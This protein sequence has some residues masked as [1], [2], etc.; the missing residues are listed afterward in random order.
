MK[1][2]DTLLKTISNTSDEAYDRLFNPKHVH[3]RPLHSRPFPLHTRVWYLV[4]SVSYLSAVFGLLEHVNRIEMAVDR[5]MSSMTAH[6]ER[7]M[8]NQQ[9][10][11]GSKFDL[12]QYIQSHA[13]QYGVEWNA[14]KANMYK[15]NRRQYIET[16]E[17]LE[18]VK[19]DLRSMMTKIHSDNK[20]SSINSSINSSSDN[21]SRP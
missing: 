10:I 15:T 13:N 19:R 11:F 16:L 4:V 2:R 21:N 17:E 6:Y 5:E 20:N 3:S 8:L 18:Q 9:G 7:L 12:E 1:I 14:T